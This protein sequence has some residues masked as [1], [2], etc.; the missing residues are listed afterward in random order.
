MLAFA[1]AEEASLDSF[2]A[3]SA[4]SAYERQLEEYLA[5]LLW[6][7]PIR[8]RVVHERQPPARLGLGKASRRYAV[9]GS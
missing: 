8:T 7:R 9:N 4:G 2:V 6:S 3:V 5:G 1:T